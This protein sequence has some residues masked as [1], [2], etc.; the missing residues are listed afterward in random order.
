MQQRG[1]IEAATAPVGVG[2]PAPEAG[3]G[4]VV[5]LRAR[6]AEHRA[7]AGLL[8]D[9]DVHRLGLGFPP[10][11]ERAADPGRVVAPDPSVEVADA[12]EVVLAV[13]GPDDE[14]VR[15]G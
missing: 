11:V 5:V 10:L 12:V 14:A 9:D 8:D 7:V 4:A 6:G 3:E 15:A 1:A 2:R 13:D